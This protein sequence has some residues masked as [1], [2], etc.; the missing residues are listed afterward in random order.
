MLQP[1]IKALF[2]EICYVMLYATACDLRLP[3]ASPPPVSW[4]PAQLK[5]AAQ[6][7]CDVRG[8]PL[9]HFRPFTHNLLTFETSL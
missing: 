1:G 2:V 3:T 4:V 6:Q 7:N 8:S 9:A 5:D